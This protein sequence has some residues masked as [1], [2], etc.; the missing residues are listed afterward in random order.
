M[1]GRSKSVAL[2][3]R[4]VEYNDAFKL[5]L[6]CRLPNPHFS[7]ELQARRPCVHVLCDWVTLI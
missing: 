2:G 6:T 1:K 3:D 5:Y 7:P 4:I